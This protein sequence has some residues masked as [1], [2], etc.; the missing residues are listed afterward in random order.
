L[1][2]DSKIP[3][4]R[5]KNAADREIPRERRE[6]PDASPNKGVRKPFDSLQLNAEGAKEAKNHFFL[7]SYIDTAC[8]PI[9]NMKKKE[10]I[11]Q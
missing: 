7:L 3:K 8:C 9:Y 2:K 6:N 11:G 1:R 10:N 4:S 5:S